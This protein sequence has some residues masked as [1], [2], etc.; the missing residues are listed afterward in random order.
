MLSNH[1]EVP[2]EIF[3]IK[4]ITPFAGHSTILYIIYVL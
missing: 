3:L 2:M 1:D 4:Y